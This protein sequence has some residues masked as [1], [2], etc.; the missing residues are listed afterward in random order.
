MEQTP[1]NSNKHI[2]M[3]CA[4]EPLVDPRVDWE[5]TSAVNKGY[6]VTV[7]GFIDPTR[8]FPREQVRNNYTIVRLD[9][10]P[11][12]SVASILR[13]YVASFAFW[14]HPRV[15]L[16]LPFLILAAPF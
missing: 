11:N 13:F 9:R 5:A 16:S 1:Q 14:A 10:E 8:D 3:L 6:S 4:H 12:V 2:L 7:V 15:L